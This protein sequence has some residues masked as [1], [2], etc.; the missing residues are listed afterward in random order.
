[1]LEDIYLILWTLADYI[2]KL[3]RDFTIWLSQQLTGVLN[4]IQTAWAAAM[5]AINDLLLFVRGFLD[6]VIASIYEFLNSM[7]TAITT[8]FQEAWRI[9]R[10]AVVSILNQIGSFVS[11]LLAA[12]KAAIQTVVNEVKVIFQLFV[13]K[14]EQLINLIVNF[15]IEVIAEVIETVK[16]AINAIVGFAQSVFTTFQNVV[17][18]ALE[19]LVSGP[20]AVFNALSQRFNDLGA[21]LRETIAEV[22]Q[23]ISHFDETLMAAI[24]EAV[25][26]ILKRLL[27][28]TNAPEMI[29]M[30]DNLTAIT[31]AQGTP[32]DY[33]GLIAGL[34]K[35][36]SPQSSLARGVVFI[37]L[38]VA[39]ALPALFQV[40]SIYA[41]PISQ[42]LAR[43]V[44]YALLGPPDVINAWKRELIAPGT[45]LDI[46]KRQGFSEADAQTMLRVAETIPAEM[47]ALA[48]R[49]R[50]LISD[51]QLA[52][53]FRDRGFTTT[54]AAVYKEASFLIP[55][56]QDLIVMAVREV[57]SPET[58]ARFGQFDDF[59]EVFGEWTAK[60]GL[61][62]DWARNYWAA[63][64]SLP[65]ATQG[66]EMF[67]REIIK[68][69]DLVLLLKSLDVMPF[70]RDQLIQLA[71]NPFTR[72]DIRRMHQL[73]VL[74]D[75]AVLK[76]HKDLGYDPEKAQLLTEFVL[77]LNRNAPG[78][79]DAELGR[80]SRA[81]ILGFYEDGVLPR[82]RAINLLQNLGITPEASGL[83]LDSVDY[84]TERAERKAETD[85]VVAQAEAGVISF[86]EAEDRLN[87][88][89]L[90]VGELQK[91]RVR[92][93]RSE[94][95]RV[96]LPSLGDGVK[97]FRQGL[98]T[99]AGLFDL[100][101]RLGYSNAWA[102]VYVASAMREVESAQNAPGA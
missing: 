87:R 15:V 36:F 10:D 62:K 100:L 73:G 34:F 60:Q 97:F 2:A 99:A 42:A 53:V 82:D 1:M 13:E 81:T 74:D 90:E 50:G 57:F 75:A 93:T 89:G 69:E 71:Y 98:I 61:S 101:L 29:V 84:A 52:D 102:S 8:A 19:A 23:K 49:H 77:R 37:F 54:W 6:E 17:S 40:G 32:A 48:F 4:W 9:V 7:V 85:L 76:A 3:L 18:A 16:G 56:P 38:A 96:K 44:P 26:N 58:T 31:M 67:Q 47:D 21:A 22:I 70:W 24:R 88:L 46:L 91:A 5:K 14:V 63:H 27:D 51:D 59:P 39:S 72:V 12:L 86:A 94:Q 83:Y 35:R 55:P 79:D 45:A 30:M 43:E 68:R 28:W 11:N 66:F 20:A 92:L 80:L 65:S 95:G 78:E 41:Q 33:Q 25:D 64:W